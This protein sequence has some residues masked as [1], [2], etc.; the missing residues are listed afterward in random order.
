MLTNVSRKSYSNNSRLIMD[1]LLQVF[2]D[3]WF[4]ENGAQD[5][6]SVCLGYKGQDII[7]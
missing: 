5:R 3:A 2:S 1:F 7:S 6:F 4:K